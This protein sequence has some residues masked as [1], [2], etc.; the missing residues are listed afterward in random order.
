MD[1]DLDNN[2][3]ISSERIEIGHRIR[4]LEL[5]SEGEIIIITDDQKILNF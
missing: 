4:D 2:K 3:F 5:S 1:F